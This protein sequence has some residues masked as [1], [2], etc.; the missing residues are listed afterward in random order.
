MLNFN[1]KYLQETDS[2]ND[3]LK[4]LINESEPKEGTVILAEF[5]SSGRGRGQNHWHSGEGQN[6]ILSILLHPGI[7]ADKFF[8]LTELISLSLIDF[9]SYYNIKAAIKWPND[10]YV[11]DNKIAGILIENSIIGDEIIYCIAGIGINVNEM[12]FPPDLLNPTS[13]RLEKLESYDKNAIL[14][15][16]LNKIRLRYKQSI[17]GAFDLLH[18][19]YNMELYKK[20]IVTRYKDKKGLLKACIKEIKPSG[21][22][23]LQLGNGIEKGYLFNEIKMVI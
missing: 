6:L 3:Y 21:E 7:F 19:E 10:I 5:Q 13:M 14:D 8:Y 12:D 4:K 9:L 18:K 1:I 16:L 23:V 22:M 11:G 17:P 20:G 2:T 15:V